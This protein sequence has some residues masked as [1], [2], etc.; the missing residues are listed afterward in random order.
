MLKCHDIFERVIPL[1]ASQGK[2]PV[3]M[4]IQTGV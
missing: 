3:F 2:S 1:K 4:K